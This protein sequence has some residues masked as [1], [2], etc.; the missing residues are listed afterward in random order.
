MHCQEL[1]LDN[2]KGDFLDFF[3]FLHPQIPDF[4]MVIQP[5]FQKCW[6]IF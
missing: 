1:H 6:D 3:S 5:E 4:Q 2:C